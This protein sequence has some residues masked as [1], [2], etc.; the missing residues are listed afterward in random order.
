V[1]G[2]R[3]ASLAARTALA[4]V[5]VLL[6]ALRLMGAAGYM[7]GFEHGRIAVI[8]CPDGDVNAPLTI[9]SPHHHHGPAKHDHNPCPYAAASALG[10]T[11]LD[12]VTLVP[13]LFFAVALLLGRTFIF[14]ERHRPHE[15]PPAIGPPLP[16]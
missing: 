15:R 5:L 10:A 12:G 11:G 7:P 6:L 14:A 3:T 16:A 8:V 4:A 2:I 1:T 13:L 9:G